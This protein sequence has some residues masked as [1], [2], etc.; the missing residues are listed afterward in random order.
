[1]V[2]IQDIYC[3]TIMD[4]GYFYSRMHGNIPGIFS[5]ISPV[6][7]AIPGDPVICAPVIHDKCIPGIFFVC[8]PGNL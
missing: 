5:G 2:I 4:W 1:M 7:N 8:I 3:G 6:G